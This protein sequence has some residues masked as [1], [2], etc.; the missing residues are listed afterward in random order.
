MALI[1]AIV[2]SQFD[3]INYIHTQG[4]SMR[5][6]MV[7]TYATLTLAYPEENLYEIIS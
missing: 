3:N 6:K 1:V 7:P 4:T 2:H 5:T